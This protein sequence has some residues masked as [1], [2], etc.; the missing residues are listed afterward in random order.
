MWSLNVIQ[1]D[2]LVGPTVAVLFEPYDLL[3][4]HAEIYDRENDQGK[5]Y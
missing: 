3:E 5:A 1:S 4:K 2:L